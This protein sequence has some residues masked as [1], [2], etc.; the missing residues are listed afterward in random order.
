VGGGEESGAGAAQWV[1]F[2]VVGG[3][4]G[5]GFGFYPVYAFVDK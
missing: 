3:G 2:V 4:C 1:G 5:V